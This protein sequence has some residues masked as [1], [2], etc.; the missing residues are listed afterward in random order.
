MKNLVFVFT[1]SS[2]WQFSFATHI[3]SALQNHQIS[4]E[5]HGAVQKEI[6]EALRADGFAPK[7]QMELKNN[8]NTPLKI[9]L[10]EGYL[11][12]PV[13]AG[14][15]ALLMTKPLMITLPPKSETKQFLYAMCTQ[16]SMSSP[17]A[18]IR[19]NIGKRAPDALLRLAQFIAQKNYQNFGA[20]QA[21]W[22]LSDKSPILSIS[23]SSKQ[24]E[25]DLQQFVAGLSGIDL[26][27][28]KR[29]NQGKNLSA[30]MQTFNGKRDDRNLIFKNDSA[31]IVSVGFY[32]E[33]GE[34]L[35]PIFE[36]V[37]FK[38]G[39]HSIRYN[40]FPLALA[41]KRYAVRMM[42]DGELYRE[43]YFMQ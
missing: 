43:H 18:T 1:A 9:E 24:I 30:I 32:N 6:P 2:I 42:K 13:E 27:K 26:D 38:P 10:E 41:N 7:L 4:F 21:V 19:Y 17:N 35:K 40:P 5:M 31:S 20:Q 33:Q 36:E 14:Y 22:S 23:A 12:D 16:L 34:L 39:S 8:T 15:Q 3:F 29:E 11:M 28:L 25:D 37:L